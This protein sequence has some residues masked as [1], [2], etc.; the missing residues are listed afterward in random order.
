M[1]T[2]QIACVP[3]DWDASTITVV[4]LTRNGRR[5]LPVTRTASELPEPWISIWH[6]LVETLRGVAPGEW[7]ATFIIG[8]YVPETVTVPDDN[9]EEQITTP[10]HIELTLHRKWD[11]N[12]TAEPVQLTMEQPE[13]VAFFNYLTS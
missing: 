3:A 8:R 4:G 11:D 7:A 9:T 6:G 10:E 12:T 5:A 2:I 1:K 13:A